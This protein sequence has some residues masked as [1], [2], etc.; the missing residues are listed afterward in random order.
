MIRKGHK[1]TA[2]SPPKASPRRKRHQEPLSVALSV[3]LRF[4]EAAE[5][6]VTVI[7]NRRIP[8]I[9][10]L[11]DNRDRILRGFMGLLL[12]A[13]VIQPRVAGQLFP[14]PRRTSSGKTAGS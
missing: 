1:R 13:A 6:R 9:G 5:D 2:D 14:R 10:G 11:F 12:R 7:D 3:S 8:M 4:G